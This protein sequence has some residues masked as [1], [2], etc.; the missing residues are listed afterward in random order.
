MIV[1]RSGSSTG[2]FY[3]HFRNK[4]D[5][6]AAALQ[7]IGDS[8]AAALNEAIAAA[9][10]P[11]LQMRAAVERLLRYLAEKPGDAR[12]LIVESSGLT[13]RLERLRRTIISSHCRSVEQALMHLSGVLPPLD[14]QVAARC[15]VGAVY[16]A[17]YHWLETASAERPPIE[18]VAHEVARFNLRGIGASSH[19]IPKH[20][21]GAGHT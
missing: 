21:P 15:W 3:F 7:S 4:E 12:I 19:V 8:I 14:P 18:A 16:E 10:D 5:V 9:A 17:A 20:A 6:F 11:Q 13:P 2:S 1:A